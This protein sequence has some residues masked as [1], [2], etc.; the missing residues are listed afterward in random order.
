MLI[1]FKFIR[2]DVFVN[3][4][5]VDVVT[6]EPG[7]GVRILLSGNSVSVDGSLDEVVDKINYG[8]ALGHGPV[9]PLR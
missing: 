3:P 1:Q 4:N 9:H 7:F 5:N 8:L 2:T 6:F